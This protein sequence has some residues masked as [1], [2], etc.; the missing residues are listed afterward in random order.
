MR[1]RAP[2]E[3]RLWDCSR[4][5]LAT[6]HTFFLG[7]GHFVETNVASS[8][9][10]HFAARALEPRV[11]ICWGW[12][13]WKEQTVVVALTAQAAKPGGVGSEVGGSATRTSR[14]SSS[15]NKR[16]PWS[17]ACDMYSDPCLVNS[18]LRAASQGHPGSISSI[19]E[20]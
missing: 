13:K 5:P 19:N 4:L 8:K 18:L 1:E 10:G 14:K 9:D 17:P 3:V 11:D 6:C 15:Q 12:R 7:P 16:H 2:E 20:E